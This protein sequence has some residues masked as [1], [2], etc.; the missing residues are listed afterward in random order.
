M[1]ADVVY[2]LTISSNHSWTLCVGH[3]EV[4]ISQSQLFQGL[5]L[6]LLSIDGVISKLYN[7]MTSDLYCGT[8][9]IF[10]FLAKADGCTKQ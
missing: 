9:Y 4:N 7:R 5:T 6:L 2:M 10:K 8:Q 3:K 1:P